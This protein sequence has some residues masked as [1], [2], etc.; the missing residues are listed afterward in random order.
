[1]SMAAKRERGPARR[2]RE[3]GERGVAAEEREREKGERSEKERVRENHRRER[4]DGRVRVRVYYIL[5]SAT[6][7]NWVRL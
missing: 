3:K 6:G 1:M 4:E 2:E 7:L 5:L